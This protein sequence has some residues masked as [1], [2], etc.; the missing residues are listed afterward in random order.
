MSRRR[1][2]EVA[3]VPRWN[4]MCSP[5]CCPFLKQTNASGR[6]KGKKDKD[7]KVKNGLDELNIFWGKTSKSAKDSPHN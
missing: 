7:D 3:G 2:A 4:V 5:L 6:G 1:A